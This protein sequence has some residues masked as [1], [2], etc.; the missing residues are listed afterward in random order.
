MSARLASQ[1]DNGS[2]A[3]KHLRLAG[4]IVTMT[5]AIVVAVVMGMTKSYAKDIDGMDVRLR[6]MEETSAAVRARLDAIQRSLDR[7]ERQ[8]SHSTGGV[9]GH[10]LGDALTPD[11]NG[12]ERP[13]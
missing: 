4:M 13:L 9:P 10:V 3:M 12:K 11:A 8:V 2:C 6:R 5:V 1:N 7:I